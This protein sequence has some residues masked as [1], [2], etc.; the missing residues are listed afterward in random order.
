MK[1]SLQ[2]QLDE[3]EERAAELD[4]QRTKNIS[5]VTY[6]NERNRVNNIKVVE[7]AMV[8]EFRIQKMQAADPF[9]RKSTAP[10]MVN[11]AKDDQGKV[12]KDHL[13]QFLEER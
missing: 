6:I 11:M 12:I 2:Q 5:S 4:R 9:K 1:L 13:F 7:T 10:T 3:L 8:K